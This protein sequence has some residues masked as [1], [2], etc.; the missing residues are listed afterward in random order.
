MTSTSTLVIHIEIDNDI[1]I[2]NG[3]DIGLC[4]NNDIEIKICSRYCHRH[5]P[6]GSER[7]GASPLRHLAEDTL[8]AWHG[9]FRTRVPGLL[10]NSVNEHVR[11]GLPPIGTCAGEEPGAAAREG[12]LSVEPRAH[13]DEAAGT[14]DES[15]FWP[16]PV[17]IR[18]WLRVKPSVHV[19]VGRAANFAARALNASWTSSS[20]C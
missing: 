12:R 3:S 9:C 11:R 20:T 2:D 18:S 8:T 1:H 10:K 5:A 17:A 6:A 13:E 14:Q 7:G 4:T 15:N 19:R 16:L